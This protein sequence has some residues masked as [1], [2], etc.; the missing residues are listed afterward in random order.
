[1]LVHRLR[2]WTN[3]KVTLV[4]CLVFLGWLVFHRAVKGFTDGGGGRLCTGR[5]GAN[6][7][8]LEVYLQVYLHV[9][10]KPLEKMFFRRGDENKSHADLQRL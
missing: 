1:M 6:Q 8:Y 3:I 10:G 2:R 7:V 4:K 9:I 5:E